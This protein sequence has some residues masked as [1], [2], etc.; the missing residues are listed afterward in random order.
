MS[1]RQ[2][3]LWHASGT[4]RPKNPSRAGLAGRLPAYAADELIRRNMGLAHFFA[5]R[6]HGRV[7]CVEYDALVAEAMLGGLLP[8]QDSLTVSAESAPVGATS[9]DDLFRDIL[10][11][12][13][14]DPDKVGGNGGA[15]VPDPDEVSA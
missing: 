10:A 9:G 11:R 14:I 8:K 15:G 6:A 1:W 3:T 13:G 12:A 2:S 5:R 4:S 7:P